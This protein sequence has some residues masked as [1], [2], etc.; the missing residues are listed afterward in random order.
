MVLDTRPQPRWL[1]LTVLSVGPPSLTWVA[2]RRS[3][4]TASA[5]DSKPSFRPGLGLGVICAASF[6]VG[7]DGL[8]VAVALPTIQAEWDLTS[9][10]GQWVLTAYAVCFGGLLL[11]GGRL[12]DLYGRRRLMVIGL[13]LFA[14]GSLA[15]AAAPT[16]LALFLGRAVQG[17]GAA[18]AMPATLS[19][20]G[21]LYP[22]GPTRSRALGVLAATASL[23]VITGALFG[24]VVTTVVGWRWVF[25][26]AAPF[27]AAAATLA[28][29][30][31]PEARADNLAGARR[32][33]LIGGLLI[34]TAMVLLLFGL[35]R[36]EH[37]G[38]TSNSAL[39]PAAV[40]VIL[41][42]TFVIW[43]RRTTVPLIRLGILSVKSLRGA[44]LG[45]GVN[46][47]AFTS[48]IY[49]G[50]LY[51]QSV[52]NYPPL[53]A[54]LALLPLD[55][56]SALVGIYLGRVLLRRSPRLVVL[57]SS[58]FTCMGLLWLARAPVPARY[59]LDLL[60]PLVILGVSLTVVFVVLTH[61][62]VA[63]VHDDE[64]G[65]AS[66]I[67]ETANHLLGGA[68]AIVVYAMAA[69]AVTETTATAASPEDTAAGYRAAFIV[70]AVLAAVLGT[71]SATQLRSGQ[72]A[73]AA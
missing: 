56:V 34:T 20:I 44:S 36:V 50:T 32:P 39:G 16:P 51:L 21:S 14:A 52:L 38:P 45:I 17:C 30:V 43:E 71:L 69:A 63:D 42:F 54:G 18:A 7:V 2:R 66:G 13:L 70:A 9:L 5:V 61:E 19:L 10:D 41:L 47:A 3:A 22:A 37:S 48:V 6:L 15:A 59:P 4:A 60:P 64:K 1:R 26:M 27:A 67:F 46:A 25:L 72:R 58:G 8:A 28:P 65:L 62:T 31:L 68:V 12:G 23:G 33:D 53:Q 35:S 24:G 49:V 57:I 55:V 11:L 73:L 29:F 40:G